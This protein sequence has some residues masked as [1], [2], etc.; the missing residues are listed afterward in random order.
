LEEDNVG[1]VILGPYTDIKE[2]SHVKRLNRI[3]SI[4]VGE[5]IIGRVVNTLGEPY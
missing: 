5:G 3:L 4:P 2:G 1:I